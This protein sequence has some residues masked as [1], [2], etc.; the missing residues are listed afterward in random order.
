MAYLK[1][2]DLSSYQGVIDSSSAALVAHVYDGVILKATQGVT[3]VDSDLANNVTVFRPLESDSFAVGFY[4]FSDAGNPSAEAN[5]FLNAL[6][7]LNPGEFVVLDFEDE[8]YSNPGVWSWA[9]ALH[10]YSDTRT[11]HL[12]PMV[13]TTRSILAI[14]PDGNDWT[15]IFY[16]CPIW[17]ADPG[18]DPNSTPTYDGVPVPYTVDL[19][20]YGEGA[21]QGIIG[22]VD[23]DAAY[24]TN[25]D[26]LKKCG[27]QPVVVES[28]NVPMPTQTPST[29]PKTVVVST[30]TPEVDP[31]SK[32]E[33]VPIRF[34]P[35]PTVVS[36]EPTKLT[37]WQRFINWLRS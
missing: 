22:L 19:L 29:P 5:F 15:S 35:T 10:I 1:L 14:N 16:N 3:E 34:V 12:L 36:E 6:W 26:T 4:H 18:Q 32:G 37:L 13:Y 25:V 23:Q 21:V 8:T 28:T 2:L 17:L 30:P 33:P 27:Y 24:F 9:F 20:Q 11:N 7:P 31:S